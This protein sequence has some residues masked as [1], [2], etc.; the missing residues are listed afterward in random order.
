MVLTKTQK[1]GTGYKAYTLQYISG[2][3]YNIIFHP[4][5]QKFLIDKQ[6]WTSKKKKTKTKKRRSSEFVSVPGFDV[7][8]KS[9]WAVWSKG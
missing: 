9:S 2:Q 6:F 7:L 8:F 3:A 5:I 4:F 1:K